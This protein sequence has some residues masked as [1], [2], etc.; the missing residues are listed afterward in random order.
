LAYLSRYA[1]DFAD[2][3]G[4]IHR[5]DAAREVHE[6][7]S[8][9]LGEAKR[10][11]GDVHAQ[12]IEE[13][14][15]VPDL[16]DVEGGDFIEQREDRVP[17]RQERPLPKLT[18][19]DVVAW[20][21]LKEELVNTPDSAEVNYMKEHFPNLITFVDFMDNY[22]GGIETGLGPLPPTHKLVWN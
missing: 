22:L 6:R 9:W 19:L 13:E 2:L 21:Y 5:F 14:E 18:S 8:E 4:D 7:L 10:T 1:G 15:K 17:V 20:A 12:V 16:E 11:M 3:H